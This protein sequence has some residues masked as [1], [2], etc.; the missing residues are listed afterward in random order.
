MFT[1]NNQV[2]T[3]LLILVGI[4]SATGFSYGNTNTDHQENET[5]IVYYSDLTEEN[6]DVVAGYDIAVLSQGN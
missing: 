5:F 3:C 1:L 2:T 6:I 4:L